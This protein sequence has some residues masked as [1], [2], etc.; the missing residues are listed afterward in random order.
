M[1][2]TPSLYSQNLF[3]REGDEC[4]LV[5]PLTL[6]LSDGTEESSEKHSIAPFLPCTCVV[7]Q[8]MSGDGMQNTI[9]SFP[10]YDFQLAEIELLQQ[11]N[12][13]SSEVQSNSSPENVGSSYVLGDIQEEQNNQKNRQASGGFHHIQSTNATIES[14]SQSHASSS[15]SAMLSSLGS[16]EEDE[17]PHEQLQRPNQQ[18]NPSQPFSINDT[19]A[20]IRHNENS[21]D[22][23]AGNNAEE[24]F[25]VIESDVD[26][27]ML[28]GENETVIHNSHLNPNAQEENHE[29]NQFLTAP[30][31]QAIDSWEQDCRNREML[32]FQEFLAS[33]NLF[34]S[35]QSFSESY[36]EMFHQESGGRKRQR[37]WIKWKPRRWW[38]NNGKL[39]VL[40]HIPLISSDNERAADESNISIL[41]ELS[42]GTAVLGVELITVLGKDLP[43]EEDFD[44]NM[45]CQLIR[46]GN[47]CKMKF[48]FLRIEQPIQGYV[49][50]RR[51]GYNYLGHGL[52]AMYCHPMEW[53][54]RVTCLDGAFVRQGLELDSDH[55]LTLN[56]GTLVPVKARS[57][58]GMGLCRLQVNVSNL[59]H[60]GWVS[61]LL[62][63]LSGQRGQIIHQLP[64]P[65]P[66]LF[67]VTLNEGAV[68]RKG[69]E[70]SSQ[71]VRKAAPG[72]ILKVIGRAFSN[73]PE[74]LC[75]ERLRLAG[76]E[77]W[78]SLRLNVRPPNNQMVV[79]L[80]GIDE[81]F[82]TDNPGHYHMT[83]LGE[84]EERNADA[85]AENDARLRRLS[86]EVTSSA[87]SND[88][89]S[90]E[91]SE[92]NTSQMKKVKRKNSERQ[93]SSSGTKLKDGAIE[94]YCL[95]C[96][97]EERNATII[98]GGTGH[99]ACCLDCSRILKGRGDKCPV[100]R[101]PI[102]AVIQQFWA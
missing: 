69:K 85:R 42:P 5:S 90:D 67:R 52:P 12:A 57:V 72:S 11:N 20:I 60:G 75:V 84:V 100:C 79:E 2:N 46:D 49:L 88:T 21:I 102:D 97:T 95:I 98:H 13:L 56:Y 9:D 68:I 91:D 54:W 74:A 62:N 32:Q 63:P 33:K 27:G 29:S 58:N 64:F 77:G 31:I 76:D 8:G 24:S 7:L 78:I 40:D 55:L 19:N 99:I 73:Y 39:V 16:S 44:P 37:N 89:E 6:P 86:I 10:S 61:E 94:E 87:S 3:R 93:R 71:E 83:A 34:V 70:L 22:G 18:F 51:G 38:Q 82:D 48:E 35:N 45:P 17:R 66:M 28:Q 25:V 14:L 43:P 47:S 53:L 1:V 26:P 4:G 30:Q 50:Y 101:L 41:G 15:N 59:P 96:L 23:V 36:A 65:V 80:V 92:N 81:T